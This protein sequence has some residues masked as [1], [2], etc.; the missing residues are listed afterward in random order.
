MYTRLV[1]L[2]F[3]L[4][5]AAPLPAQVSAILAGTVTDPSGAVVAAGA[6]TAH[7]VDPGA[8]R[9]TA[10]DAQGHYQFFSLAVGSYEIR[11]AKTGFTDQV[12]TGVHL[13]VGQSATVD[14]NLR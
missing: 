1:P 9:H 2:I 4:F 10:T 8:A 14:L 13:A 7:N 11:G 6:V 5:H 3:F 12:R